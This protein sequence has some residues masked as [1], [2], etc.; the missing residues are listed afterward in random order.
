MKSFVASMITAQASAA[1]VEISGDNLKF[2]FSGATSKMWATADSFNMDK[3]LIVKGRDILA[4]L[5]ALL[6]IQPGASYNNAAASCVDVGSVDGK[7]FGETAQQP[8]IS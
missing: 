6:A 4:E 3:N 1:N 2:V 5:D 8:F 7:E